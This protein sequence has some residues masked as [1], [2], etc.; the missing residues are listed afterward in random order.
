M[1]RLCLP[2]SAVLA[3]MALIAGC[4]SKSGGSTDPRALLQQARG[5]LDATPALH[6]AL[7]S[8]NLPPTGSALSAAAGDVA[9]TIMPA[10]LDIVEAA[11]QVAGA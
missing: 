4:G 7:T 1:R 5:V 3:V 8:A 2:A 11:R 10:T 6:V 9:C